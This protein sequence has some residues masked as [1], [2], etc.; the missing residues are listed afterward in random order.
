MAD[1]AR[2]LAA[3]AERPDPLTDALARCYAHLGRREHSAFELRE[4]LERAG[5]ATGVIDQALA[6]VSEQGYLNDERYA[7]LLAQDR[8]ELDG[9]GVER[10]RERMRRAGIDAAL[11]DVVLG[12]FD[13]ASERAAAVALLRRRMPQPPADARERQRAFAL[14][15]RQGFESEVAYDAVREHGGPHDDEGLELAS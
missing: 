5:F 4:R 11:I 10:I 12:P 13:P 6:R 1:P 9:W 2:A 15:V 3:D 7:R 8:R 14:L